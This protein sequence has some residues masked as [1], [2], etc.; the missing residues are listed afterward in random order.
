[1]NQIKA[2]AMLVAVAISA[3][4]MTAA[5]GPASA[6]AAEQGCES[7]NVC[8]YTLINF[9]GTRFQIPCSSS[10][11]FELAQNIRSARNRCGN[12]LNHLVNG[13]TSVCM[14]SGGDRPNP[15]TFPIITLPSSF[16]GSC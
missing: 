2:T 16:G 7:N 6:L 10:G 9:E 4:A 11:S 14:N 3:Y 8:G 13:G 5:I 1:M 15:G 12:K